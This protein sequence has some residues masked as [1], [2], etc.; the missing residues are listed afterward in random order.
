[1]Y[2]SYLILH[3]WSQLPCLQYKDML[4]LMMDAT[5]EEEE[6][7]AAPANELKDKGKCLNEAMAS[8]DSPLPSRC[9]KSLNK[10]SDEQIVAEAVGLMMAGYDTSANA[11]AY[12]S[13]LLALHT[14]IQQKL[15]TEIDAYFNDKPVRNCC[16]NG[17]K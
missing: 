10:L 2:T 5:G 13:Y 3:F 9:Q 6:E 4:Q 12:T 17:C 8:V 11:L 15:Q 7:E 1:M 14:E 16:I